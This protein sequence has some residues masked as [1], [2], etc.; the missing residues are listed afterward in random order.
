MFAKLLNSRG[1][2]LRK[3]RGRFDASFNFAGVAG[4]GAGFSLAE[5]FPP[6]GVMLM[7][8]LA[9]ALV[10]LTVAIF[11]GDSFAALAVIAPATGRNLK[12]IL[13]EMK[14]LQEEYKGK[15]MPQDVGTKFEALAAEAKQYQDE[16]DRDATIRAGEEAEKKSRQIVAPT[17]PNDDQIAGTIG[18]KAEAAVALMTLGDF[19]A[20]S[21]SLL[22]YAEKGSPDQKFV[23]AK[24][25]GAA[26]A[27]MLYGKSHPR[28]R[29][30]ALTA[31]ELKHMKEA[32]VKMQ[33]TG[34]E[35]K[36]VP[37]LG[38]G[39]IEPTR[40]PEIVRVTEHDS[41][42]LRD[43]LD[44]SRTQS[45]AVKYTRIASVTRAGAP[46][47]HGAQKPQGAMSMDSVTESVRTIAVWIPVNNQQIE[48][49]PQ[50]SGIINNELLYDL[51]K[52]V[53]ELVIFGDGNGENF[54]GI[55]GDSAVQDCRREEGDTL[56]DII[57]RGITDVRV[58]SYAPNAVTIDPRDWEEIVLLKGSDNRY[59]HAIVSTETEQRIWSLGVVETVAMMD[60]TTQ[61]R[62]L[63]VGDF[64]RAATLWDRMDSTI[65][66]GWQNDQ[67]IRNQKTI[68]A[69]LRAAFGVKRPNAL[70][71]H[72]TSVG[73]S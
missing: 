1:V 41:L 40:V 25:K 22:D 39:V 64:K 33:G 6:A 36:T 70:R 37:V 21:K 54:A 67:M 26:R 53:E 35:L 9:I 60:P 61:D 44:I 24:L 27:G 18:A 51:D 45:D 43:V 55:I 34:P 30:V 28:A 65:A 16:I 71:K 14:K 57:R 2:I 68:L 32:A 31:P 12:T 63:L 7:G 17:N 72:Q 8:L 48:D 10:G 42:R 59:I 69:E 11:G 38:E 46:V 52:T 58:S 4:D 49:Y 19:V 15:E 13:G 56:I 66:I 23:I 5:V 20:S 29:F 50:L 3:V 73:G 62:Y 47:A